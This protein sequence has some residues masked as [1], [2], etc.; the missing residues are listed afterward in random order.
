MSLN[1]QTYRKD[2]RTA[3]KA[4]LTK[5]LNGATHTVGGVAVTFRQCD[6]AFDRPQFGAAL[7]RPLVVVEYAGDNPGRRKARLSG[8]TTLRETEYRFIVYTADTNK[9]WDVNDNVQDLLETLFN[10]APHEIGLAGLRPVHVGGSKT[11]AADSSQEY[12]I[13]VRFVTFLVE[14]TTPEVS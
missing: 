11:V 1:A 6:V 5:Y 2:V 10:G 3:L 9:L 8:L 14:L 4:F 12:Q 7:A 13:A